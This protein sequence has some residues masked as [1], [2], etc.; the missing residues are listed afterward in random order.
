MQ[1]VGTP[2]SIDRAPLT[3]HLTFRAGASLCN[4]FRHFLG[5]LKVAAH[6][7][8]VGTFESEYRLRMAEVHDVLELALLLQT[9]FV[10][11]FQHD[12]QRLQP[13][14]LNRKAGGFHHPLPLLF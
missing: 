8:M 3:A 12:G 7:F 9:I 6:T 5:Q 10:L 1:N 2:L 11:I 14:I 4:R 13:W